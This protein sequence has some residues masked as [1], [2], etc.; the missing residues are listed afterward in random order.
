MNVKLT[1]EQEALVKQKIESGQYDAPE[2]V[3][4]HAFG[5]LREEDAVHRLRFE[6][7]RAK[8]QV[9]IDQLER[10]EYETY[11]SASVQELLEGIKAR[12]ETRLA[13]ES[14]ACST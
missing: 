8:I 6:E 4:D 7:L 3:I 9:G 1:P 2:E 12:T 10:G 11:D 5:L 14:K 13:S